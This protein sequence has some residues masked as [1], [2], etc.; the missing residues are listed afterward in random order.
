MVVYATR[1]EDAY[2]VTALDFSYFF[3][4]HQKKKKKEEKGR[5]ETRPVVK[6]HVASIMKVLH[7]YL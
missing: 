3:S 1:V 4:S 5:K 7:I 6:V 2:Q